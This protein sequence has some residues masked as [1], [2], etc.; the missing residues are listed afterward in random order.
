M[1]L[2]YF[3]IRS[4]PLQGTAITEG[5][6]IDWYNDQGSLVKAE[7]WFISHETAMYKA[8][9]TLNHLKKK[10]NRYLRSQ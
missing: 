9:Q 2:P 7:R 10:I 1:T 6:V 4:E 3:R 5:W 8:D